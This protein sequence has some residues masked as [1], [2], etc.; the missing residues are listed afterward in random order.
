M[1]GT[2]CIAS[3]VPPLTK[4]LV[5]SYPQTEMDE[6]HHHHLRM[7]PKDL[8]GPR[9]AERPPGGSRS[10]IST[11]VKCLTAKPTSGV[12]RASKGCAATIMERL[13]IGKMKLANVFRKPSQAHSRLKCKIG[14]RKI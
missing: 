8:T 10:A 5:G 14:P 1:I 2:T 11:M 7:V 3:T 9:R 4:S 13:D 6:T 12:S